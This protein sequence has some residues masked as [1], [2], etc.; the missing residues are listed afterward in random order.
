M[1]EEKLQGVLREWSDPGVPTMIAAPKNI[2]RSGSDL[3][4]QVDAD[5]ASLALNRA[6]GGGQVTLYR[7]VLI[8]MELGDGAEGP[9]APTG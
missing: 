2:V 1:C 6:A 8:H 4:R 7:L 5:R 3:L 9:N